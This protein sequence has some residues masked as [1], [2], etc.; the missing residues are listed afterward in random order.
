MGHTR[1]SGCGHTAR[2]IG[3]I[4]E[5]GNVG[6]CLIYT[7]QPVMKRTSWFSVLKVVLIS[8]AVIK[9]SVTY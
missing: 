2:K 1:T 4:G 9:L 3:N 6:D 5:M 7:G 8:F